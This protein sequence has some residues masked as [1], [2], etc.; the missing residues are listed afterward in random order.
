MAIPVLIVRQKRT[1]VDIVEKRNIPTRFAKRLMKVCI[2][3]VRT[4]KPG[5]KTRHSVHAK[6]CPVYLKE[7]DRMFNRNAYE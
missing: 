7:K 2:N 1:L 4:K 5:G 6:D 3:C